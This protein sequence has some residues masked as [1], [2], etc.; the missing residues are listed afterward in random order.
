VKRVAIVG[1]G[2]A[3]LTLARELGDV[4][5]VVVFE[6]SRGPGGRMATR[7]ADPYQF[8]HGAQF[9]TARSDEFTSFINPFIDQGQVARWDAEFVEIESD[10]IVSARSWADGPAHYVGTPRMNALAKQM[11]AGVDVRLET[12]V[13]RLESTVAGWRLYDQAAASLGDY[14][15][16]VA[17]IPAEQAGALMPAD[18]S[19][20]G[21]VC[22]K[23]MLGCYSLM[24]GY[25][26]ALALDWQAAFVSGADISWI[27]NDSSKPGRPDNYTLLVHS[28]NRWAEDNIDRDDA[29]VTAFLRQE[30]G[31]VIGLDVSG[32]AH[33]ALQRWRYANIGRQQNGAFFIDCDNRL[34]AAGDWCI[35]GRIESAYLSALRLA[36]RLQRELQASR[37]FTRG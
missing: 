29:S 13:S 10:R 32:A 30:L 15:W 2:I 17:A 25:E 12:R 22:R 6:K 14:D 27:S 24:L 35:H 37:D 8:D 19:A 18:F 36:Q 21:E 20:R 33:V 26:Q 28:T 7:Q 11:A 3:G 4:A 23:H 5:E 34:A 9:F 16:V 1:A 31:R